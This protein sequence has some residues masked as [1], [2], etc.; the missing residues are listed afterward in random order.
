MRMVPFPSK[1][2]GKLHSIIFQELLAVHKFYYFSKQYGHNIQTNRAQ[3]S[4]NNV[5]YCQGS[6]DCKNKNNKR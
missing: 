1:H 2:A 6:H 4:H 3:R 5:G